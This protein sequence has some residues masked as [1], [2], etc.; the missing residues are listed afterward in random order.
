MKVEIERKFLA[1]SSAIDD[2]VCITCIVQGYLPG[3]G[4]IRIVSPGFIN[5]I[6]YLTIKGKP[7]LSGMT[8]L[9]YEYEI[10]VEDAREMLENLCEG[11]PVT[12]MRYAVPYFDHGWEVDVFTGRNAG[13]ILAEIELGS[14][15]ESF[16]YPPWLEAEVTKDPKYTNKNLSLH[17]FFRG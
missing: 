10:P 6:G 16:A 5:P 17:P 11:Y 2:A 4:R 15:D 14:E 9:E 3:I 1:K 13:L 8:R 7:S 12:K